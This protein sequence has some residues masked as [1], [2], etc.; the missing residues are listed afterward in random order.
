MGILLP[1]LLLRTGSNNIL[2]FFNKINET[3]LELENQKKSQKEK[4]ENDI[5]I[6]NEKN[7][8]LEENLEKVQKDKQD[9]AEQKVKLEFIKADNEK[10]ILKEK[11]LNTQKEQQIKNLQ[12]NINEMNKKINKTNEVYKNNIE[13]YKKQI[14]ENEYNYKLLS[15]QIEDYKKSNEEKDNKINQLSKMIELNKKK[16]KEYEMKIKS[17][18]EENNIKYVAIQKENILLKNN[19][20]E[21]KNINKKKDEIIKSYELK[22]SE[23]NKA[24]EDIKKENEINKNTIDINK[25][26]E[27]IKEKY[28]Q[29]VEEKMNKISKSLIKKIGE[30]L[31]ILKKNYNELYKEKEFAMNSK[32]EEMK[33]F[34][35]K[36][37]INLI[38][39][40]NI[41]LNNIQNIEIKD[42]NYI[43]EINEDDNI[44]S[45]TQVIQKNKKINLEYIEDKN[46]ILNLNKN[47]NKKDELINVNNNNNLNNINIQQKQVLTPQGPNDNQ[48]N[49]HK[50]NFMVTPGGEDN[51]IKNN[52]Q[53]NSDYSFDCTNAMYLTLYI[54]EGTEQEKLEITLRNNGIK[55]WPKNT[56]FKIIEPSDFNLDDIILSQQKPNE[57]KSYYIYFNGLSNYR[58]GEY[59][60]NLA[61]C[62]DE[63]I[64][65]ET[66]VARVKIKEI[67]NSNKDI[68]DNI[69][70]INEFRETFNLSE[71]EFPNDKILTIL[72]ENNF[73]F[74]EAFGSLFS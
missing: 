45:K 43:N 64:Y 72:Q 8:K 7:K 49:N 35:D 32:F 60:A 69:D 15:Q 50:N 44:L 21:Q 5:A 66:L 13:K 26:I 73:N 22:I 67:N 46:D 24:N 23:L 62:C 65:G 12:N 47:N 74:E 52:N 27:I 58:V 3:I 61:F 36:S 54:Y 1:F 40:K 38:N 9:L 33:N 51:Q 10:L 34:I 29:I 53:V 55:T 42:F 14:K 31:S 17:I 41:N 6:L 68:E 59:Q 18:I 71:D 16:E 57:E 37:N 25:E 28:Q 63:K 70:K 30:N 39:K 48:N 4:Y 19:L 2:Q 20:Q 11:D 56:K